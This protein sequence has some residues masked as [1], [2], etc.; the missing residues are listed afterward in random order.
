MSLWTLLAAGIGIGLIAIEARRPDRSRLEFRLSTVTVAAVAFAVLVLLAGPRPL[1]YDRLTI[2]TPGAGEPARAGGVLSLADAGDPRSLATLGAAAD[3][4]RRARELTVLGYG[5]RPDELPRVPLPP[6]VHR[7]PA[8]PAG[9]VALEAPPV[10]VLGA[11]WSVQGRVELATGDSAWVV[12]E[13]PGGPRDSVRVG[14]DEPGFVLSDR[15]RHAGPVDY[16]IRVAGGRLHEIDTIGVWVSERRPPAVLVLEGSPSFET[17]FLKRWLAEQG[18][19]VGIRTTVS[20]DRHRTETINEAARP[21]AL[22]DRLLERYDLVIAD[23][24]ALAGL[25]VAEQA[26]LARAVRGGG[27]LLLAGGADRHLTRTKGEGLWA[28]PMVGRGTGEPRLVRPA[29]S[30]APRPGRTSIRSAPAVLARE[31]GTPLIM[32][33][34]GDVLGAMKRL[35][36]GAVAVT[37]LET[38]SRWVLEGDDQLFAGYWSTLMGAVARDTGARFRPLGVAPF[39][40]D[41]RLT[42][43]LRTRRVAGPMVVMAPDGAADT[44]ALAQDPLDPARWSGSYWPR[45]PGWYR[46]AGLDAGFRIPPRGA[47]PGIEAS[48]RFATMATLATH[49]APA[50]AGIPA[51]WLRLLGWAVLV[52]A[53]TVLWAGG[54]AVRRYDGTTVRR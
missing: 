2:R 20:R 36:E 16:R 24:E 17:G 53:M 23:D 9:V 29:W 15:P 27:G 45:Q 52:G 7:A 3:E 41:H 50:P 35:D 42:L 21:G 51:S 13:D 47:W 34:Q 33:A 54:R 14:R 48:T 6:I 43:E 26:A 37:M 1:A 28:F 8:L 32:D 10:V 39:L 30:D 49:D 25:T 19:A 44:V 4:L 12:L 22:S 46:V 5:F 18:G 31:T 38:P 11:R 40:P